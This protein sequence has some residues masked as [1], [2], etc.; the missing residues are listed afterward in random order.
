LRKRNT[1]ICQKNIKGKGY[2]AEEEEENLNSFKRRKALQVAVE[3][4]RNSGVRQ[5][6]GRWTSRKEN[7]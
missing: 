5:G 6:R 1:K 7:V 3:K 2:R 4:N